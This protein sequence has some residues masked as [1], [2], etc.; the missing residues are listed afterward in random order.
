MQSVMKALCLPYY[1][2][3]PIHG[4][5]IVE[6]ILSN[7]SLKEEWQNELKAIKDRLD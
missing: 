4:A 3:P 2:N 6:V 1:S 5:R 7:A